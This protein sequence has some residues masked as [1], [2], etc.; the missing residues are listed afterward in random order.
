MRRVYKQ[1]PPFA[2][3]REPPTD[4]LSHSKHPLPLLY[5][6][7]YPYKLP[8]LFETQHVSQTTSYFHISSRFRHSHHGS[9]EY[10]P[11]SKCY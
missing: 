5:R 4:A 3:S 9:E 8:I 11:G 2:G 10:A 6:P 1:F 7:D